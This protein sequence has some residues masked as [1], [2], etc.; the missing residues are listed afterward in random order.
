M[1]HQRLQAQREQLAGKIVIGI[2][3]AKGRQ[4]PCHSPRLRAEQEAWNIS[5]IL[6]LE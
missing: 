5:R 2:D 3:P 1:N 4:L 6:V